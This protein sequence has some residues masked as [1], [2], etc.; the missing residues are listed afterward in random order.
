MCRF[1]TDT[2]VGVGV[3]LS[4]HSSG[5]WMYKAVYVYRLLLWHTYSMLGGWHWWHRWQ[6]MWRMCVGLFTVMCY[7]VLCDKYATRQQ[8][9]YCPTWALSWEYRKKGILD[10]IRRGGADVIALQVRLRWFL[11]ISIEGHLLPPSLCQLFLPHPCPPYVCLISPPLC[12]PFV[13]FP[14]SL[15]SGC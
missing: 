13:F 6:R 10:E 1:I 4:C 7:N 11:G 2:W 12:L 8:Y 14:S 3:R 15:P 5:R 9:G